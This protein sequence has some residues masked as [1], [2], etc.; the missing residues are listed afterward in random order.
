M[1]SEIPLAVQGTLRRWISGVTVLTAGG[2]EGCRAL[3]HVP[4]PS[5]SLVFRMT[6]EGRGNLVVTGPRTRASYYA[7]KDFPLCLIVRLRPG[8]APLVLAAPAR[9]LADRV[10]G[11]G[12][13]WEGS[14]GLLSAL[15]A[16][17]GDRQ[18]VLKHLETALLARITTRTVADLSRSQLVQAA[19]SHLAGGPGRAPQAMPIAAKR[20]A[21]SE[22]HLRNLFAEWTGLPPKQF[23]RISRISQ[24]LANVRGGTPHWAQLA[25]TAGYYDQSHM[26]AEFRA[27]MGVSPAAFSA[28]HLPPLQYC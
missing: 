26:T 3:V 16:S 15:A 4:D 27:M 8:T 25:A 21:I 17:A 10:V 2:L 7:S 11:V 28:G 5:I 12:E 18:L 1:R 14:Q 13:L 22:R 24:V 9:E 20:L 19:A 6:T 23:Q